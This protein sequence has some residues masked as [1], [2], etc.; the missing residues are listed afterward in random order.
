MLCNR[1]RL[2]WIACLLLCNDVKG[3]DPRILN[4]FPGTL[5][6]RHDLFKLMFWCLII[7]GLEGVL[8][9]IWHMKSKVLLPFVG[10]IRFIGDVT[11][12]IITQVYHQ[13]ITTSVIAPWNRDTEVISHS[14]LF[15][16]TFKTTHFFPLNV[17]EE[18][19]GHV[20]PLND[21]SGKLC[22]QGNHFRII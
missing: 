3:H 18:C 9:Q 6:L 4:V 17:V 10:D 2:E 21:P 8:R 5:R 20:I 16:S 15:Y 19:H 13:G 11:S 7:Q 14:I 22:F 12:L 1:G